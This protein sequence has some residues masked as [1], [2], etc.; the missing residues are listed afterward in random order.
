L[1]VNQALANGSS[2][3]VVRYTAT[4]AQ[5]KL[6]AITMAT[7]TLGSNVSVHT[8]KVLPAVKVWLSAPN[9]LHSSL[10]TNFKSCR[11]WLTLVTTAESTEKQ[12]MH[13]SDLATCVKLNYSLKL[14]H[15][16]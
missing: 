2:Q 3:N 11:S 1:H 4:V 13:A 12:E 8:T 6:L 10:S 5:P 14:P 16:Y 9:R 7:G 15:E